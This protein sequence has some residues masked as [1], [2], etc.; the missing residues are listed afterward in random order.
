VLSGIPARAATLACTS[1]LLLTPAWSQQSTAEKLISEGHYSRARALVQSALDRNPRDVNALVALSTIQWAY[2]QLDASASTAERAVLAA[3]GSAAAHAQLL[4]ALGA[5]LASSKVASFEKLGLSR[6]F[7]KEADR[8]L[9]LDPGN[10][11]AHE[12]LARFYW[13]APALGGGSRTKARQWLDKLVQL[14][15]VRGYALK[16]E[17]DATESDPAKSLAAVQSDWKNAVA[18]NRQ[19]YAAYVGLGHCLLSGKTNE[20][21]GVEEVAHKALALD[22]SRAASYRLLAAVYASSERWENLDAALKRART[23][24]PDDL[25]A[26]FT[27]AQTILDRNISSQLAR[28]EG[29]L[30]NY[31]RQPSEGLEPTLAVAHWRLGTVLEKQGRRSAARQEIESALT[32]DPSLDEAKKDLIRL[33]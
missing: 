11:Y 27:A 18:A 20:L 6:R 21:R 2:A 12:A 22:P 10:V 17:L 28:A 1:L 5:K 8:T 26:D 32:L 13:Y 24:V 25:A 29:Y 9:Q 23:A 33:R 31:L 3:D 15:A 14:D 19:S 7:R 16:A 30:R 4:N